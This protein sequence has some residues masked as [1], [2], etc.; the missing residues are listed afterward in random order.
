MTPKARGSAAPH[1]P[2]AMAAPGVLISTED[3]I[4]S[5]SRLAAE[6]FTP[7]DVRLLTLLYVQYIHALGRTVR[8][9]QRVVASACVLFQRFFF[10]R[11]LLDHDPLLVAP[12]ALWMASKVEE[13]AVSPKH[14]LCAMEELG[15]CGTAYE[16]SHVLAAEYSLLEVLMPYGLGIDHPHWPLATLLAQ[17]N[18]RHHIGAERSDCLVQTATFLVNDTCR[19][20]NLALCYPARIIA[21]SCAHVAGL[22]EHVPI[23]TLLPETSAA[24]HD[25]I[26][27][28]SASLL[29]LYEGLHGGDG[30]GACAGRASAA[31]T[32]PRDALAAAHGRLTEVW[33][34]RL[35]HEAEHARSPVA[36][37]GINQAAVDAVGS[38]TRRKRE[39]E[40]EKTRMEWIWK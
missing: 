33:A 25:M 13:S 3:V 28:V 14:I 38:P 1:H 31:A 29:T 35:E 19:T 5:E 17:A 20:A 37:L 4:A 24:E 30:G 9:R 26:E 39:R 10:A 40:D 22:L 16:L 36:R 11:T 21:L 23:R 15:V 7:A 18:L 27:N 34:G 2:N 12:I 8:L 32:H 6:G